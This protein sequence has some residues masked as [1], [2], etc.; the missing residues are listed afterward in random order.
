MTKDPKDKDKGVIFVLLDR[1][2]KQRLP[3]AQEMKKRVDA[4]ELLNEFDHSLIKEVFAEGRKIEEIVKRNPGY[5]ELYNNA[6]SLWH[7]IVNKDL[8]N[9]KKKLK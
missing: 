4:G 5:Q 2:N 6:F 1:F 3:R 8:E 7:E 9:Q